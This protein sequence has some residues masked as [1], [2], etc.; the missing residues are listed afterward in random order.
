[1]FRL[2]ALAPGLT[3]RSVLEKFATMQMID[4]HLPITDSRELLLP[5]YNEPELTLLLKKFKLEL[6]AQPPRK[7]PLALTRRRSRCSADRRR[8]VP[9]SQMLRSLK[10]LESAKLG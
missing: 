4:V 10:V 3:P 8:S 6:P 9:R 5:R 1:M 7:S 2:H